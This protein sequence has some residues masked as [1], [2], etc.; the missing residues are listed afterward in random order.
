MGC[1]KNSR[2]KNFKKYAKNQKKKKHIEKT[3]RNFFK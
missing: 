1:K 2:N 3:G